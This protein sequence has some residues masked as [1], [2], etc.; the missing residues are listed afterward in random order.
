MATLVTMSTFAEFSAAVPDLA[1]PIRDRFERAGIGILGT[2]RR[3]GAPRVSP[4]EVSFQ[5][6]RLYLGM[7]PGSVKALDLLRDPRCVLLN[8]IADRDDLQ[9]EGKLSGVARALDEDEA[10]AVLAVAVAELG[11]AVEDIAGSHAFELLVT[12]AA[13]QRVDGDAWTTL[14]WK[15]GAPVRRRRRSGATGP[16]VELSSS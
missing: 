7:M 15:E 13:W 1:G 12:E 11:L 9:G 16:V 4:I 10:A 8:A 14:S 3:S 5:A 2:L 6:D